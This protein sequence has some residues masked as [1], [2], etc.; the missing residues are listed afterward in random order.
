MKLRFARATSAT[1]TPS[2]SLTG[3]PMIIPIVTPLGSEPTA[4]PLHADC[5]H[6]HHVGTCPTCQRVAQRR[7]EM[8]LAAA[9]AARETWATRGL[10]ARAA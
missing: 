2:P 10:P 4:H 9:V 3:D 1:S 5:G 6:S 7:S 8:Q